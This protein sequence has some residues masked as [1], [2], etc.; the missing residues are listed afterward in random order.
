MVSVFKEER[1]SANS[2]HEKL[3]ANLQKSENAV[4]LLKERKDLSDE[5]IKRLRLDN[6]KHMEEKYQ[7]LDDL[8]NA[9]S[10]MQSGH[11][12]TEK[13]VHNFSTHHHSWVFIILQLRNI[14]NLIVVHVWDCLRN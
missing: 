8:R 11:E 12:A 7:L 13:T 4:E 14:A 2:L 9:Q 6:Q 10:S 3:N 1:P 5:E